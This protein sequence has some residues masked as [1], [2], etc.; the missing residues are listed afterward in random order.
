[1]RKRRRCSSASAN[2]EHQACAEYNIGY[3]FGIDQSLLDGRAKLSAT[4]FDTRY[5]ISSISIPSQ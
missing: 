4:F 5:R 3:D 2:M 1:M